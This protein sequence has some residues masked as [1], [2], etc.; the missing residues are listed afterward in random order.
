MSRSA[1]MRGPRTD[2]A[3]RACRARHPAR[4]PRRTGWSRRNFGPIA[5]SRATS[6][7]PV[8]RTSPR[9]RPAAARSAPGRLPIVGAVEAA[10]VTMGPLSR[11]QA[12]H[13]A[14]GRMSHRRGKSHPGE[15]RVDTAVVAVRGGTTWSGVDHVEGADMTPRL[16]PH[17]GGRR[18]GRSVRRRPSMRSGSSARR[19]ARCCPGSVSIP[20]PCSVSWSGSRRWD[21]TCSR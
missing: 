10:G 17:S 21:W 14:R 4:H 20:Q 15:M 9:R 3:R 5:A 18:P 11:R 19:V 12:Q 13:P 7:A 6:A 1:A 2:P 16:L 8:P